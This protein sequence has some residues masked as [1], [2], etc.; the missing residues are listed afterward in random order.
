MVMTGSESLK[1]SP[2]LDVG[3]LRGLILAAGE[4]R[5]LH[6]YVRQTK[7]LAL[8]KQY[9]N[10]VG[11]GSLLEDTFK[12][13]EKL[14]RAERIYTVISRAH[15]E[16]AEVRRQL[17][18]RANET[19][20]I[21]P[22]NKE[23]GP[24][25]LLPLMYVYKQCAEA[26]VAIFPS[27]HFILEEDRFMREVHRAAEVVAHNPG[28]IVLLAVEPRQAETEYGYIVPRKDDESVYRPGAQMI[29]AFIEKPEAD[30]ARRLIRGGALWNTMTMVF[31]LG[32][33]LQLVEKVQPILFGEF[34]RIFEA[35]GTAREHQAI[36]E[37]YRYLQPINFSREI[38]ERIAERS[39]ASL[40]VLRVRQVFWSDV[41]SPDRVL[42][43]LN[44][45]RDGKGDESPAPDCS[46]PPWA[47]LRRIH[48][49]IVQS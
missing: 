47:D 36:E 10:L 28:R 19:V 33:L 39:P 26:I 24:G 8:P 23:T 31:K 2:R 4:G 16:H 15:L 14:I 25:V 32:T 7:N 6:S 22:A 21:Q 18:R 1:T 41:G 40:S 43:V 38:I 42:Q 45:L 34:R 37:V 12:R 3:L 29:S 17:A 9:I 35:L 5:R 49:P 20:I 13:A 44:K 11:R 27:D 48:R 46:E 30:R